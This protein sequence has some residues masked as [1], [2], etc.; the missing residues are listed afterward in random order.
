MLRA[1]LEKPW[2]K[3][4][5]PK[6]NAIERPVFTIDEGMSS[7]YSNILNSFR[8]L[9]IISWFAHEICKFYK[10]IHLASIIWDL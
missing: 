5:K 4:T 1:I 3:V 10:S 7:N 8:L 9:S 6:N 2:N